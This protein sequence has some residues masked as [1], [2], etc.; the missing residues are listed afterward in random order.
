MTENYTQVSWR[1]GEDIF[2]LHA[3]DD[4]TLYAQAKAFGLKDA[5]DNFIASIQNGT[6]QPV[7]QPTNGQQETSADGVYE[8]SAIIYGG[9]SSQGDH[10]W[11]ALSPEGTQFHKWG[12]TVWQDVFEDAG[13]PWQKLPMNK[14]E[15]YVPNATWSAKYIEWENKK[16]ET[17]RKVVKLEPQE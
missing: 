5:L 8:I 12:V 15:A 7:Q 16:G 11:K 14:D 1:R 4:K 9:Q 17:R 6:A 2:V 10:Y 13:I 3:E